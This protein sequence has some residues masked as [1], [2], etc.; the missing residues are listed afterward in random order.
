MVFHIGA[1]S[2]NN[3]HGRGGQLWANLAPQTRILVVLCLVVAISLTPNGRWWTWGV[4][5]CTALGLMIL[6]QVNWRTLCQRLMV[7]SAFI[8]VV[9]L[10]TLFHT[11]GDVLWQW[12]GLQITTKG[13]TILGSV[14]IKALLCLLLFNLLTLTTTVPDLL[15]GLAR[16]KTPPLLLAIVAAMARYVD[17]LQAEVHG[18]QRAATSRNFTRNPSWRRQVLGNMIGI[19]FLRTYDRGD[20]IHQAMIARGYTGLPPQLRTLTPRWRDRVVLGVIML[21][22]ILGQLA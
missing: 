13:L 12:G 10:G 18:L 16:L 8:S 3:N 17:V 9:L 2:F 7:E 15:H 21:I 19:L 14:S 11:G 22:G 1:L 6:A 4:Y 5:G 20:R